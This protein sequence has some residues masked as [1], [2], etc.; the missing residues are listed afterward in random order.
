MVVIVLQIYASHYDT[1]SLM[2]DV[3]NICIIY[4]FF[5]LCSIVSEMVIFLFL[6]LSLYD[7]S[8]LEWDT[9]LVLWT[10]LFAAVFRPIGMPCTLV[11][12]YYQIMLF[13]A[14]I[15][16]LTYIVNQLRVHKIGYKEQ[17]VMVL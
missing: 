1:V 8:Q 14:G 10:L 12:Y 17:F 3:V 5:F 2:E 7:P 16:V 15:I 13:F 6:G 9:G 4:F 11:L